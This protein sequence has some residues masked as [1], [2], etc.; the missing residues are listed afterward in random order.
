ML[1]L[2]LLG[3]GSMIFGILT[4]VASPYTLQNQAMPMQRAQIIFGIFCIGLGFLLIS[5]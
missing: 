5:L 4:I 3:W 2:R 1:L